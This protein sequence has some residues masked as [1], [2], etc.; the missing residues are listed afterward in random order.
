MRLD[1]QQGVGNEENT[2]K[3]HISNAIGTV[4]DDCFILE[5]SWIRFDTACN[6]PSIPI[7]EGSVVR[8]CHHELA[9]RRYEKCITL[10][11]IQSHGSA[12]QATGNAKVRKT[13]PENYNI[14]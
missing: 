12:I 11:V 2:I 14:D 8:R 4:I 9:E 6:S 13:P 7:I 10:V 3:T 5:I 1:R